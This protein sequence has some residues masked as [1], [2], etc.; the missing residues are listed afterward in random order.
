MRAILVAI[1]LMLVGCG[2]AF[3]AASE[4][5][6]KLCASNENNDAGI[7]TC[8]RIIDANLETKSNLA[9]TYAMLPAVQYYFRPPVDK[10]K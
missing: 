4:A 8:T 9:V 1:G 3:G 2:V 7:A 6:R 5:E 10:A